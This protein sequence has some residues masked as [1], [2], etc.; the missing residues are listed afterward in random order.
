MWQ[1]LFRTIFDWYLRAYQEQDD[2]LYRKKALLCGQ[3]AAD[4]RGLTL[5]DLAVPAA[6]LL[7]EG[8]AT[9]SLESKKRKGRSSVGSETPDSCASSKPYQTVIDLLDSLV[10]IDESSSGPPSEVLIVLRTCAC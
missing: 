4:V 8:T 5:A 7:E 9:S 6:F 1:G 3:G 2:A 10:G